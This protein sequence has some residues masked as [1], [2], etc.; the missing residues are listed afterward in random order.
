MSRNAYELHQQRAGAP[1]EKARRAN[2]VT[3]IAL[4]LPWPPSLNHSHAPNINGGRYLTARSRKFIA[5]VK[6]ICADKGWPHITG[7][8][9]VSI[10][11]FPPDKRR[12]DIDNR[13]KLCLD[14]L[15]RAAVFV[16]DE[17]VVQLDII[18][19]ISPLAGE[20]VCHVTVSRLP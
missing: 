15:Q 18:R 9:R 16:D 11:L 2:E 12:F 5:D 3:R 4:A 7:R 8:L 17:A 1:A 13:A 6:A 14:A 10:M 20:G 19:Q